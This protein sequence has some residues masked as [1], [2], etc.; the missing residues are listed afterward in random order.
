MED[1]EGERT[2]LFTAVI[3]IQIIRSVLVHH[4]DSYRSNYLRMYI[5]LAQL[6]LGLCLIFLAE[7]GQSP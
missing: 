7:H 3:G 5:F 4:R 6:R 1:R 2:R